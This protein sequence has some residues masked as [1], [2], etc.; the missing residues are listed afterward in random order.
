MIW[1]APGVLKSLKSAPKLQQIHYSIEADKIQKY[2]ADFWCSAGEGGLRDRP[3][4]P[5][6]HRQPQRGLQEE[7]LHDGGAETEPPPEVTGRARALR[8]LQ[9]RGDKNLHGIRQKLQRP[10]PRSRRDD[11]RLQRK[12]L[13]YIY[14]L[15]VRS[16]TCYLILFTRDTSVYSQS[17]SDPPKISTQS[18]LRPA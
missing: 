14:I 13:L 4:L 15:A 3:R 18:Q 8:P 1:W 9:R 16:S 5:R 7:R 12:Q 11:V 10:Q 17:L 6:S 2:P